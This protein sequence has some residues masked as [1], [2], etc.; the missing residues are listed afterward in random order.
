[1]NLTRIKSTN[2]I[3]L[4]GITV[5][6]EWRDKQLAAITLTDGAGKILRL[7]VENYTVGAFIAAKPE[8]KTMHVV[9]GT[10]RAINTPFREE[11]EQPY[12]ANSRRSELE[13]ADVLTD[14]KVATE[15]I[16]IPF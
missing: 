6:A 13:Q 12:E 2:D 9:S 3:Q 11:F 14:L 15:D 5:D 7:V 4:A 16:E 1:M 10:V 8:R